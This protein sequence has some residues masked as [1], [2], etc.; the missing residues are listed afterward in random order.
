MS[1]RLYGTK[2][3]YLLPYVDVRGRQV[4]KTVCYKGQNW[5]RNWSSIRTWFFCPLL[6]FV[7]F[8]F[9]WKEE[10]QKLLRE[11]YSFSELMVYLSGIYYWTLFSCP[12]APRVSSLKFLFDRFHYLE[13][14]WQRIQ[15]PEASGWKCSSFLMFNTIIS[16]LRPPSHVSR[17]SRYYETLKS[18]DLGTVLLPST[19]PRLRVWLNGAYSGITHKSK[20]HL[21]SLWN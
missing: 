16:T 3:S 17:H 7:C 13:I 20:P 10:T 6:H 15:I 11:I 9:R 4:W 1:H 18:G 14:F 8:C 2:A 12:P 21:F 19:S 5:L